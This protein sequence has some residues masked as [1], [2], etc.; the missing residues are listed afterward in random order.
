[1]K[2]YILLRLVVFSKNSFGTRDRDALMCVPLR[3][4][5][6]QRPRAGLQRPRG[7][8]SLRIALPGIS[9]LSYRSQ[10]P[11]HPFSP[12]PSPIFFFP[13]PN[14]RTHALAAM[15]MNPHLQRHPT[16]TNTNE[17]LAR[18]R[19]RAHHRLRVGGHPGLLRLDGLRHER[20]LRRGQALLC[21][22][23]SARCLC[24]RR[25]AGRPGGPRSRVCSERGLRQRK[26]LLCRGY[27]SR[28]QS[29]TCRH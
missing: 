5:L 7:A 10:P 27:P 11:S 2:A 6:N 8:R 4:R 22:G 13:A 18:P 29:N 21:R 19:P 24:E 16:A 28:N 9:I 14:T 12:P 26:A 15:F 3:P 23:I 25:C 17:P 1:M 20:G